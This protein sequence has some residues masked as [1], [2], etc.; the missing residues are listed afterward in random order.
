MS[1][2]HHPNKDEMG[3]MSYW[4]AIAVVLTINFTILQ[5]QEDRA[6]IENPVEEELIN[7]LLTRFSIGDPDK[8]VELF[9]EDAV[10]HFPYAKGMGTPERIDGREAYRQYLISAFENLKELHFSDP[11]IS[12][13]KSGSV[14]W[15]EVKGRALIGSEEKEYRQHYVIKITL[16]DGAIQQYTE[17]WNP[18]M[19]LKVMDGEEARDVFRSY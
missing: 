4:F 13:E 19:I 5:I 6:G 3:K 15:I 7:K 12:M 16:N 8:V 2:I 1:E 10:I 18:L 14:Y 9:A 11:E 17:Y